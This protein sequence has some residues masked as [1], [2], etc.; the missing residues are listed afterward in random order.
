MVM[1]DAIIVGGALAGSRTAQ[2]LAQKGKKILLLEE[3]EKV[4]LPCKCTGLVSWRTPE[5]VKL[6]KELIV[7]KLDYGKF[8]APDGTNFTLK[9]KK[10]V[11]VLDRP[12]LDKFIFDEAVKEGAEVKTERFE[13]FKHDNGHLQVKTSKRVYETKV[14]VGADGANSTVAQVA[15]LEMPK[16]IYVGMQ[17]TAV[18]DFAQVAELWFGNQV[19]PEFF[20]WVVPENENVARIGLASPSTPKVY[21]EK[22]LKSRLGHNGLKPDVAGV[23]RFGVMNDTVADRIMLVGDAACQI[24]PFSIDSE[25]CVLVNIDGLIRNEKIKDIEKYGSKEENKNF[26]SYNLNKNIYGFSL[27][28][29]ADKPEFR[30]ISRLLSH[31]IK[32]PLYEIILNK[33]FR[34]KTTGSHSVMI[35]AEKEIVS[36]KVSE[37]QPNKDFLLCS[38]DVPNNESIKEINL[39]K[40]IVQEAPELIPNTRVRDS[41]KLI[42]KKRSDIPRSKRSSYWDNDSIPLKYFLE[43]NIIPED[44]VITYEPAKKS[45]KIPNIIKITPEFCR[46]LGYYISE[47]HCKDEKEIGVTFGVKDR[48]LGYIEDFLKCLEISF[49]IKPHK[50]RIHKNP[51]TQKITS[52]QFAFGGYLLTKI[53][54]KVFKVGTGAH[55]KQAPFILFNV[56]NS[57][58]KEF[59]KAYL[60]GD[61]TIRVRNTSKRRN[62]SAEISAKSVSRKLID[63]ITLLS[64]QLKL[65]P[66]ITESFIPE[67]KLYGKIMK[68]GKC[69]KI[70]FSNKHDLLYLSDTFLHKTSKLTRHLGKTESKTLITLPKVFL[71]NLDVKKE[72]KKEFWAPHLHK[73]FSYE[74]L[75]KVFSKINSTSGQLSLLRN[76][77]NNNILVSPIKEIKKVA[78]SD[79]NVYDLEV[80][81]V[82]TFVGGIGPIVLHNSGGG[83][84]YGLIASQICTDAVEKAFEEN[85]F[86]YQFLKQNYDL[87]WKKKLVPGINKGMMFRKLLYLLPDSQV[88]LMFNMIKL[89]GNKILTRFDFDLLS[90]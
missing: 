49:G 34:I 36:K 86:D 2:L 12:G 16:D 18:G 51:K 45:V 69:Y 83:I 37:L 21:Y 24:K 1:Y 53:F 64:L 48:K 14:L 40:L 54:K 25:E 39:I 5:T 90:G 89:F 42:Y 20:A 50:V 10:T 76:I 28:K 27:D 70:A 75:K 67:R 59:L 80:P 31:K 11:Y 35:L 17:T 38:L 63:D 23:I 56:P 77:V 79:D 29:F 74:R 52:Y 6:P 26:V 81:G 58:K 68:K 55:L 60:R 43:K 71:N 32:E 66:T 3:H 87:E 44:I 85:K 13:T 41:K 8:F 82:N 15:G 22:F 9:S 88:N 47:G 78:P 72:L 30:R 73:S 33:G 62:W 61:G 84:T 57:L 46:L 4:G 19:A 7:N 65:N